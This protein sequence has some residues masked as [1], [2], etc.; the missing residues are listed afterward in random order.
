MS[1]LACSDVGLSSLAQRMVGKP[2]E[3]EN[4][5]FLLH[6]EQGQEP[7]RGGQIELVCIPGCAS[8]L[9]LRENRLEGRRADSGSFGLCISVFM[10][11]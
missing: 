7:P 1:V 9:H 2:R 4:F 3:I 11:T 6:T 8:E 10:Q 5:R